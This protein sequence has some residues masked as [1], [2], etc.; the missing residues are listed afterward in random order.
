[1][2]VDSSLAVANLIVLF[3]LFFTCGCQNETAA[4]KS[5]TPPK[6][7]S[8]SPP[9]DGSDKED[10]IE[11]ALVKDVS[12]RNLFGQVDWEQDD[13]ESQEFQMN[14]QKVEDEEPVF[15]PEFASETVDLGTSNAGSANAD[16]FLEKAW[17]K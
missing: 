14:G 2:R 15:E 6:V 11:E 17:S 5:V 4:T 9:E 12:K 3:S 1:M 7:A 8:T 16:A 10:S 13:E